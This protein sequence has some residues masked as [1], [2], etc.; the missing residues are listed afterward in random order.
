MVTL[1]EREEVHG[2]DHGAVVRYGLSEVD[3]QDRMVDIGL[4]AQQFLYFN[5]LPI[6][7]QR[8]SSST[9][10][11]SHPSIHLK[12]RAQS[13]ARRTESSKPAYLGT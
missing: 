4:R 12:S 1:P 9:S 13:T 11:T 2:Y 10:L 8:H 6:K 3:F 5:T 7:V